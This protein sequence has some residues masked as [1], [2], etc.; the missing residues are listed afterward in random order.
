MLVTPGTCEG[1]LAI[2]TNFYSL[3]LPRA[4]LVRPNTPKTERT[5]GL[6]HLPT[7]FCPQPA[8]DS[9]SP[10]ISAVLWNSNDASTG[11]D[12]VLGFNSHRSI[13][14]FSSNR[15]CFEED[16][17]KAKLEDS[18]EHQIQESE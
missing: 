5:T 7:Q 16:S 1:L 14:C 17:K 13:L 4:C 12:S 11:A 8:L 15:D 6:L 3:L 2:K 18:G 9:S 10:E